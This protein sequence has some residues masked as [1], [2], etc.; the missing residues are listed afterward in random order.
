MPAS[1][2]VLRTLN[3]THTTSGFCL[4]CAQPA[5]L[6]PWLI[7]CSSC[8]HRGERPTTNAFCVLDGQPLKGHDRCHT[9]TQL[10]GQAHH[11][12]AGVCLSKDLK[13]GAA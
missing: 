9:C 5:Q 2:L 12:P 10:M 4:R 1:L 3:R 8:G 6:S 7:T 13:R 11:H